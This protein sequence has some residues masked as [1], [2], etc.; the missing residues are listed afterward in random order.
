[1]RV[2]S[3]QV[4]PLLLLSLLANVGLALGVGWFALKSKP[5]DAPEKRTGTGQGSDQV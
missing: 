1:M 5:A 4:K 3:G 2:R